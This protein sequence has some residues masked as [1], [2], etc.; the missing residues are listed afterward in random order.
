[1]VSW[2]WLIAAIYV[3]AIVGFFIASLLAAASR[4]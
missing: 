2:V 3:G 1:M 4:N